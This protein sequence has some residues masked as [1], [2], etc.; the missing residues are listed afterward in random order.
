MAL[1]FESV[2]AF[3]YLYLPAYFTKPPSLMHRETFT[4]MESV[5][6]AEGVTRDAMAAPRDSGKSTFTT[7]GAPLWLTAT[8]GDRFPFQVILGDTH[9]QAREWVENIGIEI[10]GNDA[11][12]EDFGLVRGEVWSKHQIVIHTPRGPVKIVGLG[13]RGKIRGRR[14]LQYRPSII[15][16]DDLDN[17]KNASSREL[18]LQDNSWWQKAVM[19]A[20][21]ERTHYW[22]QGTI[23][24]DE[25]ILAQKL[26][27]PG[28]EGRKYKSIVRW[29][30]RMDLWAEWEKIR[31]DPHRPARAED[32]LA[33]HVEHR[34]EMERGAILGWPDGET[35]YGLMEMRA[36][37]GIAAFLSERQNEPYDPATCVL[38]IDGKGRWF[39]LHR[40]RIERDDGSIVFL[41][42]CR[43]YGA[44]DPSMGLPDGDWAVIA[45]IAVD[46]QGVA[47]V[48]DAWCRR[49][50]P[51]AQ[52]RRFFEL[53]EIVHFQKAGFEKTGFQAML[54]DEFEREQKRRKAEGKYWQ[55][56]IEGL[57]STR[58][59]DDRIAS[60]EP[61]ITHGWLQFHRGL[62]GEFLDHIR[63]WRPKGTAHDDGGDALEM[64]LRTAA[65]K[66]RGFAFA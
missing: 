25:T 3:C 26:K 39:T 53:N 36:I 7:F 60:L 18:C 29:P 52:V 15:I 64:A 34:A 19:N 50:P 16:A 42:E 37:D 41:H 38:D 30:E 10:D 12:R 57:E 66:S 48:V 61:K 44:L 13:K 20:G 28:W 32:A 24:N 59:K 47:Y 8:R 54:K 63:K 58:H 49:E 6:A 33:F 5:A 22:L 27:N 4:R 51:S 14:F 11:L 45:T 17:D 23:L 56:P 62:D 2:E 46:P 43:F 35:L 9:E 21:D 1:A 31:M 40:D 65:S 55:L